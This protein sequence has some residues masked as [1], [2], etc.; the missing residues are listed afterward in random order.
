MKLIHQTLHAS[1]L[2][3]VDAA[4][5]L[6]LADTEDQ[7]SIAN[8]TSVLVLIADPDATIKLLISAFD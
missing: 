2:V 7:K 5:A 1:F 3:A 4:D 6:A 8:L